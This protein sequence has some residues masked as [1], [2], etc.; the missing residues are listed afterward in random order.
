MSKVKYKIANVSDEVCKDCPQSWQGECRAYSMSHSKEE[1]EHRIS[2]G[3]STIDSMSCYS[4]TH[5]NAINK[6]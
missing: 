5:V 4:V 6:G 2:K 3:Q 1:Y